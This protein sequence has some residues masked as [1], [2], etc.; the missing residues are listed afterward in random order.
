MLNKKALWP[1][2]LIVLS[3]T[4]V[5]LWN[6]KYIGGLHSFSAILQSTR[7]LDVIWYEKIASHGYTLDP[8]IS[9]GQ[10]T[11]FFPLF[12]LIAAPFI[13]FL[14]L[15]PLL[16]LNIVQKICL[17]GMTY[18]IYQWSQLQQFS[19]KESLLAVL[20]HPA[21]VF[22]MVPYTESL[23]LC[24]LFALLLSWHK[25]NTPL[26]FFGALLLGLCRP[27]GLFLLPAAGI[28]LLHC[29]YISLKKN[30]RPFTLRP[31]TLSALIADPDFKNC[32]IRLTVGIAGALLALVLVAVVMQ[33]S[34][35]DW[36]AFYRYR[37]LWNEKP[38]LNNLIDFLNIDY[39]SR[40]PRFV[41]TW[42]VVWGS[43]LLARSGRFFEGM[44]CLFS[45]LLPAYQG[46]MGDIIRYSL[47]AAPAWIMV[48][49]RCKNSR[50]AQ[51]VLVA[52]SISTAML[53]LHAWLQ[54]GWA[55]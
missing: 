43:Y 52:F 32:F 17:V 36:F 37:S 40:L 4:A 2:A 9:D 10:S 8:L 1:P 18:L 45:I 25:K 6:F 39:G 24:C 28:T 49:D 3:W 29:G 55:G 27:T 44:L 33:I 21:L 19:A 5:V 48:Y 46:K 47:G 41:V 35:G 16:A 7:H 22:L 54:R 51:M 42:L 53:L 26:F 38:G 15:Q 34:V 13:H 14:G 11:V 30:N 20:L 31:Q 23:Y 12:P 50:L